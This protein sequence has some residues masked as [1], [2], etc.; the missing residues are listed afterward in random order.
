[1]L[2]T[3]NFK[4]HV[5]LQQRSLRLSV[6]Y[7]AEKGRPGKRL[8]S[9]DVQLVCSQQQR[10]WLTVDLR[11]FDI[12]LEAQPVIATIQWLQ[13]EKT[14]PWD[15]YF[16]IPVKRQAKQVTVERENSEATWTVHA[17]QPSFYFTTLTE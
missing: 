1:M 7:T 14:D 13:S 5:L 12:T 15:K 2:A 8:L 16:S 17:M 11:S 6:L 9:K 10:G 4:N 3:G